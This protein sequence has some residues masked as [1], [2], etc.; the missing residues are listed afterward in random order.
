MRTQPCVSEE[1]LLC[2]GC[3]GIYCSLYQM[4]LREIN[5]A[6]DAKSERLVVMEYG[7]PGRKSKSIGRAICVES[8]LLTTDVG[9]V[10]VCTLNASNTSHS[11]ILLHWLPVATRISPFTITSKYLSSHQVQHVCTYFN[12]SWRRLG[13]LYRLSTVRQL[14]KREHLQGSILALPPV[15]LPCSPT[16]NA[17]SPRV[18]T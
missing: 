13:Q 17:T 16:G 14:R 1:Y 5:P 10:A 12:L 3:P 15:V 9:L 18:P 4:L 6:D 7:M 11:C 2:I 8:Q